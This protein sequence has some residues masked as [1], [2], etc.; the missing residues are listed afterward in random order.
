MCACIP[1]RQRC[2]PAPRDTLVFGLDFIKSSACCKLDNAANKVFF[3]NIIYKCF[4]SSIVGG[5]GWWT[6]AKI[7]Q[8]RACFATKACAVYMLHAMFAMFVNNKVHIP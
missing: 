8:V 2:Q 7:D 4:P 6:L 3:S 5:Q 1:G